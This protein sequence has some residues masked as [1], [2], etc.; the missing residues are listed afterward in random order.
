[1]AVVHASIRP[2]ILHLQQKM[3]RKILRF[4]RPQE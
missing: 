1:M 2:E 3:P 4:E